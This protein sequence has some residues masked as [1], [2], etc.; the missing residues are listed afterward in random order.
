V[1]VT[2]LYLGHQA[3][4]TMTAA[5][6]LVTDSVWKVIEF[7]LQGIVFLLIGL[8]LR[9]VLLGLRGYDPAVVLAAPRWR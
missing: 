5:S 7:L 8:Q 2:G 1:V 6:R 3:P 4:L 9:E